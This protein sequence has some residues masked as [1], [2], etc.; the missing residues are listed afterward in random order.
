[1]G[2]RL[3]R[4]VRVLGP[5]VDLELG[6]LPRARRFFGSIPLTAMRMTSSGRRSSISLSVRD[7]RPPG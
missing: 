4:G 5:G 6:D 7:L 3:L 1:M 2:L